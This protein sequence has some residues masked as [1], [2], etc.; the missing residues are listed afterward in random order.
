VDAATKMA[1]PANSRDQT[2]ST[3]AQ[4]QNNGTRGQEELRSS[5]DLPGT[6][7][8]EVEQM[9][10]E[11]YMAIMCTKIWAPTS[12]VASQMTINGKTDIKNL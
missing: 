8:L 3:G 4:I 11:V 10:D 2:N 7:I 6:T 5:S 1:E 9:L 12:M